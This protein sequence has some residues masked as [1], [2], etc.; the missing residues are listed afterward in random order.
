MEMDLNEMMQKF[1]LVG[2]KLSGATLDLGDLESG[3]RECKDSII[4]RVMGEKI[5]SFT[6]VKN[7]ATIA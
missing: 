6:R 2:N 3:V 7:F 1:L 4:G 5:A